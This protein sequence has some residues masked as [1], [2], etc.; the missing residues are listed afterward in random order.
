MEESNIDKI[1]LDKFE[2]EIWNKIPHIENS[3]IVN[4]TP[5]VDLTE[6]LKEC[7]KTI[8]KL[9]LDDKNL[10]I[11][12]KF[13]STL[14]SGSIKVRAAAHIIHNAITSGKLK[15]E[16]TVIE[17]TSGNFGIALG[18]LSK[19]GINVVNRMPITAAVINASI[20]NALTGVS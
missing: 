14:L 3:K 20:K 1:L 2:Q 10:K 19:L 5:L 11:Y 13:D 4:P 15:S 18:Q 16:Q 6:D 8:Y 7:A 9:D 12:G 17:A